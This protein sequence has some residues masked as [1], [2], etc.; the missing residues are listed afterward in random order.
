VDSLVG[1]AF[2]PDHRYHPDVGICSLPSMGWLAELA[3]AQPVAH[4]VLVLASIAVLGLGF[5]RGGVH[6]FLP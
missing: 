5:E 4:S 1:G 2:D 3:T 6:R